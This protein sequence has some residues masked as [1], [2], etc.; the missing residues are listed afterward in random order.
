MSK[1]TTHAA[2]FETRLRQLLG[3][4]GIDVLARGGSDGKRPDLEVRTN[5]R[6][7][8]IALK[9][10]SENRVDV[11]Q[12]LMAA[13]LL[14][15]RRQATLIDA[16][17]LPVVGVANLTDRSVAAV[18]E[19]IAREAPEAAWG[20]LDLHGR[21]VLRGLPDGEIAAH[22]ERSRES[23]RARP[24]DRDP[25]SDLGQ[26]M[27]KVLIARRLPAELLAAPR[28]RV[29]RPRE[30]ARFAGV[31]EPTSARWVKLMRASGFLDEVRGELRL[32]RVREF[33]DRWQ[34]KCSAQ[35]RREIPARFILPSGK[36]HEQLEFA[37]AKFAHENTVA[38]DPEDPPRYEGQLR[39]KLGPRACFAL[40][41]ASR[42]LGYAFVDGAPVHLYLED[43]SDDSL[44]HFALERAP[45]DQARVRVIQPRWPE[46]LFRGI[47]MRRTR[48]GNLVP[49]AD[50]VQTWLDVL[51]HPVRGRE[52]AGELEREVLAKWIFQE[53]SGDTPP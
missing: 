44:R 38:F 34:K 9:T 13:A 46:A 14:Q 53:S 45:A 48:T 28:V 2:D 4:A 20:M 25:F 49:T 43:I 7:F 19:F 21:L 42:A 17:A 22:G 3:D 6:L 11:L 23:H 51:D 37:L 31:S 5:G 50:V 12:G 52:L 16:T 30:L 8:A 10:A 18:A 29:R 26:W 27:A 1:R 40:F 39:W 32:V 35:S 47:V 24:H 15:A 33:F 41:E 36:T